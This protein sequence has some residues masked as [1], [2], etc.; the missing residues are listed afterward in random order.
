M[1]LKQELPADKRTWWLTVD[2][3]HMNPLGDAI[4]AV[5]ILRA[6]GVPDEKIAA[7]VPATT[8]GKK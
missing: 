2:G 4:M 1:V 6:L 5:A 3:A 7:S 8:T